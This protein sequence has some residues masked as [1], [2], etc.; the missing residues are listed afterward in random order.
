SKNPGLTIGAPI[1]VGNLAPFSSRDL[2]FPVSMAAN[3]PTNTT[4]LFSVR[5]DGSQTCDR[6]GLIVAFKAPGAV[7]EL[8]NTNTLDNV[9]TR[10][11]AWTPT[12]DAFWAR[13]QRPDLNHVWKG[14]DPSFIADSQLVSPMLAVSATQ[15]FMV[16]FNHAFEFE[17][18]GRTFFDGGV[19]E[20]ST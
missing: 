6:S 3:A 17:F 19:I 20:V 4:L 9:E 14:R 15:P 12:G 16:T 11:T 18:A 13:Q 10:A 5:I 1:S 8:S 2:A 7:D